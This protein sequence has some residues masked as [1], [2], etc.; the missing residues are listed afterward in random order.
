MS[1]GLVVEGQADYGAVP[2]L[3]GRAGVAAGLPIVFRGQGL[4]CPI[5]TLVQKKLLSPT[6][7]QLVRGH[8]KV[9]VIIDRETRTDCPPGLARAVE[10]E[11]V[12]QLRAAYGYPRRPPVS[13][14]CPDRTLENWLIADPEGIGTHVYM[15]KD[16]RRRVGSN[17]DGRDAVAIVQWAY[18]SRRYHKARDAPALAARVRVER[19]DVRQRSRSLRKLLREAGV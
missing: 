16:I 12:R 1:V 2:L 4:E 6:R 3:L 11:L 8:S 14:V 19:A 9:L 13:V 10:A 15:E 18:G 7:A 17:A 5:S